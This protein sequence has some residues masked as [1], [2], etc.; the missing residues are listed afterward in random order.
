MFGTL[1][2]VEGSGYVV[3]RGE[4]RKRVRRGLSLAQQQQVIM[5]L[6]GVSGSGEKMWPA[7]VCCWY[8]IAVQFIATTLD[9]PDGSSETSYVHNPRTY[10]PKADTA[11]M[12]VCGI[13]KAPTPAPCF[14]MKQR[15]CLDCACGD[16]PPLEDGLGWGRSPSAWAREQAEY[17]NM[18]MRRQRPGSGSGSGGKDGGR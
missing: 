18:V 6:C 5:R 9:R 4:G 14:V 15:I 17:F 1:T 13:C 3:K 8:W 16:E 12:L 11:P 10:P 7:Q 2:L